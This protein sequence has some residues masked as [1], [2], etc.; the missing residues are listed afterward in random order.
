LQKK[1]RESKGVFI[2]ADALSLPLEDNSF[3]KVFSVAVLHHVPSKENRMQFISEAY[4]V[5]KPG[6]V[7]V[8]T[9]WNTLQWE[10]AK[11]HMNHFFKKIFGLSKLDFG[12]MILTFGKEKRKRYIHSNSKRGLRKLFEKSNFSNITVQ[13]VKR[14]SGYA[15]FVV[16]AK[17]K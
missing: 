4:R 12:D 11:T 17:K 5:L 3:D 2:H 10:F 13:E 1:N 16:V 7:C 15:N 6:G 8:L 14:K 9:S